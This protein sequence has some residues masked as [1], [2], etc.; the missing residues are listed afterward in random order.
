MARRHLICASAAAQA[1]AAFASA[2]AAF[3]CYKTRQSLK[4]AP[5]RNGASAAATL[6]RA[7]SPL[8]AQIISVMDHRHLFCFSSLF[9]PSP[10]A[11]TAGRHFRRDVRAPNHQ[12]GRPAGELA[13][14]RATQLAKAEAATLI[15]ARSE[16]TNGAQ[17]IGAR[18]SNERLG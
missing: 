4:K 10:G 6:A 7:P 15:S 1:S 12:D 5:A 14:S 17:V 8:E 13:R 2:A 18:R 3:R 11:N 16:L 9:S